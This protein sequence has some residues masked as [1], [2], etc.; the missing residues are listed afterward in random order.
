MTFR[1]EP[2][3]V[4]RALRALQILDEVEN[5]NHRPILMAALTALGEALDLP[6]TGEADGWEADGTV[7]FWSHNGVTCPTHEWVSE[8]EDHGYA[9][10]ISELADR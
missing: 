4:L 5:L 3:P 8:W 10:A 2:D 6:C 7:L 1:S 9:E